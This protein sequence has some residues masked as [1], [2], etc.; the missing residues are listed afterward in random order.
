[1][2][3]L[4]LFFA[5]LILLSAAV[6]GQKAPT[7]NPADFRVKTCL[8]SIGMLGFGVDRKS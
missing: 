7:G 3:K 4:L 8:H 2:K 5:V 6:Y 1:M